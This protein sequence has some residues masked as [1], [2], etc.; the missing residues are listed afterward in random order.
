MQPPVF[1][2]LRIQAASP[3]HTE[4]DLRK[5][6]NEYAVR[7]GYVLA[8]I[9]T[10]HGASDSSAFADLMDALKLSRCPVVIVPSLTHFAHL[11][12]LRIAMRARIEQETGARVL[13]IDAPAGRAE[14][15]L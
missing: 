3:G 5:A 4:R 1:G 11:K 8:E 15:R 2:Y 14:G 7:K 13:V 12:G 10:E 9:F 6:M